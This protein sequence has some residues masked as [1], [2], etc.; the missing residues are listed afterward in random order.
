MK[1]VVIVLPLSVLP[2]ISECA[3]FCAPSCSGA[4][5]MALRLITESG[6]GGGNVG[7]VWQFA[8]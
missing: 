1:R 2:A 6:R 3:T 4:V 8:P 7:V 5:G